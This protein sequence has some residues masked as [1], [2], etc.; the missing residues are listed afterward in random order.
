MNTRLF[1]K[2]KATVFFLCVLSACAKTAVTTSSDT[3][4]PKSIS[5]E[6]AFEIALAS[7]PDQTVSQAKKLS[8][9]KKSAAVVLLGDSKEIEGLK[10]F[11]IL[12]EKG[13]TDPDYEKWRIEYLLERLGRT[14]YN[15]VRNGEMH[16]GKVG[17]THLRYKWVKFRSEAA[18]AEDFVMNIASGSRTSGDPYYVKVKQLYYPAQ[19]VLLFELK[20]L[21]RV[22][23]DFKSR[24]IN[25]GAYVE[26]V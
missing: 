12:L 11:K 20:E 25:E 14:S 9:D 8:A 24:R 13:T 5:E 18:T 15:L 3:L 22:L 2:K 21:D 4:S 6:E 16:S 23:N 10:S 1:C 19:D 26:S 17:A 7:L